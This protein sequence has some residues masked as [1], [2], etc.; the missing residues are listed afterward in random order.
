MKPTHFVLRGLLL[1][2]KSLR[3]RPFRSP[4]DVTTMRLRDAHFCAFRR[5]VDRPVVNNVH[6]LALRPISPIVF[7]L[8]T[9]SLQNPT[10][11][12]PS[13]KRARASLV[14]MNKV[15]AS[16]VPGSSPILPLPIGP[17]R[18][19][20]ISGLRNKNRLPD[21]A[22]SP[23]GT[24]GTVDQS[25]WVSGRPLT[26]PGNG[27]VGLS[28]K[29]R[30]ASARPGNA[31]TLT[32]QSRAASTTPALLATFA[33]AGSAGGSGV[34]VTTRTGASGS[35]SRATIVFSGAGF[36]GKRGAAFSAETKPGLRRTVFDRGPSGRR[37]VP[38]GAGRM[39]GF[40]VAPEIVDDQF[41]LVMQRLNHRV[42]CGERR[43]R[44]HDDRG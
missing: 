31:E 29:S 43:R 25:W 4:N 33:A 11:I 5:Q 9:P 10:V 36:G 14:R 19:A 39:L 30:K 22:P 17:W 3:T 8:I 1:C 32:T 28:S 24:R 38:P 21:F 34:A 44:L 37:P 40:G 13:A 12:F 41:V 26:G 16:S 27:R 15:P 20:H 18:L 42:S 23:K 7:G 35:G 6:S 2:K